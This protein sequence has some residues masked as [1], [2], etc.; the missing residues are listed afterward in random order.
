[1]AFYDIIVIFQNVLLDK[2][3]SINFSKKGG[4]VFSGFLKPFNNLSFCHYK[5]IL[6]DLKKE[7]KFRD[8]KQ[9][10][11]FFSDF[12]KEA[13]L[14]FMNGIP[15]I[16]MR[17]NEY[18]T[19]CKE[20]YLINYIAENLLSS[21]MLSFGLI[22]SFPI[23]P[24]IIIAINKQTNKIIAGFTFKGLH[25][26]AYEKKETSNT[27]FKEDIELTKKMNLVCAWEKKEKREKNKEDIIT[28]CLNE[29]LNTL[30]LE[31]MYRFTHYWAI[32]TILAENYKEKKIE[33]FPIGIEK[34]FRDY[35]LSEEFERIRHYWKVRGE[36]EHYRRNISEKQ[37]NLV[38]KEV[39]VVTQKLMLKVIDRKFEEIK[40]LMP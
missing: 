6:K 26:E 1:M 40:E 35:D 31:E 39:R 19:N 37:I 34:M 16:L 3:I 4:G 8:D 38:T 23:K 9:E 25:S 21:V 5:K 10:K 27:F 33:N 13:S 22:H 36:W 14:E 2:T 20:E 12:E 17:I 15:L 11:R 29:Y 30:N 28:K 24:I 7:I 32:L 18:E